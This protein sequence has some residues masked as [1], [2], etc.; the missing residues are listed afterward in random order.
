MYRERH[1]VGGDA[2]APTWVGHPPFGLSHA[3][4]RLRDGSGLWPNQ[5]LTMRSSA[6]C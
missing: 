5:H 2:K 1:G 3:V 4:L 6:G